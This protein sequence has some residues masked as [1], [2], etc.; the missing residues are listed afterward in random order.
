[1]VEG[2]TLRPNVETELYGAFGHR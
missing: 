2:E 1:M